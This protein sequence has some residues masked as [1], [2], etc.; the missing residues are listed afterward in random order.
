MIAL[1]ID[2]LYSWIDIA[3]FLSLKVIRNP[4]AMVVVKVVS[5][6]SVDPRCKIDR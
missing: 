6:W 2:L 4:S 5:I 1:H 3:A